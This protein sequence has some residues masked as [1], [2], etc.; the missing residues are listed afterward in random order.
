[1]ADRL[2]GA[3]SMAAGVG[4]GNP[5]ANLRN[6]AFRTDVGEND[7]MF[8]RIGLATAFHGELDRLRGLEDDDNAYQHHLGVQPGRGHG[9][10]YRPGVSWIAE[11][12]RDPWPHKVVW[13]DQ[14]LDGVWR[15]RFYWLA[16]PNRP[17]AETS[18]ARLAGWIDPDTR[19]IH[20][21]AHR[22]SATNTD[23]N[24]TH[25]MDNVAGSERLPWVEEPIELLLRDELI[26]LDEPLRVV[27]NGETVFEG[28]VSRS[29]EVIERE[30]AKR[31]DPRQTPTASLTVTIP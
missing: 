12:K 1:M 21:E 20:L 25:G 27:A 13:I 9:I 26:D 10:D 16:R 18:D 14:S 5:P 30:F 6:L 28:R 3:N 7:T 11:R 24:R 17:D 4:L 23:G 15:D 29:R 22:L 8:D 19:T 2:A 31:P